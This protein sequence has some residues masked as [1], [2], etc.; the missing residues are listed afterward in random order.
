[1][2]VQSGQAGDFTMSMGVSEVQLPV[3]PGEAPPALPRRT[4][5]AKCSAVSQRK[6]RLK[7]SLLITRGSG[8]MALGD[9]S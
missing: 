4:V 7:A 3:H 2:V 6:R 8:K 9:E 5:R 1:M